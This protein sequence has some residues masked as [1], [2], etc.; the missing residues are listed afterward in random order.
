MPR[1]SEKI[2]CLKDAAKNR[3]EYAEIAQFFISVYSFVENSGENIGIKFK[4][5]SSKF[6]EKNREGLV[7]IEPADIEIEKDNLIKFVDGIIKTC[8]ESGKAGIDELSKLSDV[9]PTQDIDFKAIFAA[10]LKRDRKV[11]EEFSAKYEL[12]S[13]LVEYIFEIPL[14]AALENFVDKITDNQETAEWHNS[15]CPVCGSRAGMSELSATE[16]GKRYLVCSSCNYKWSF[17][18]LQC[19]YCGNEESANLFY[20]TAGEDP[21]I[22]VDGCKKCSRYI[23]TRDNRVGNADIPLDIV[24]I[25]TIHL[26]LLASKEGLERG[27]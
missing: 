5:D 10:I 14:K 18:R 6:S 2:D 9:L 24:D 7:L 11:I 26:D 22:R 21:S 15:F 8:A 17:K 1:F 20:F 27:K 12:S 19:P 25:L 13:P 4:A 23:K 3:A 16:D